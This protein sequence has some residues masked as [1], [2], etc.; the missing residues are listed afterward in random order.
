MSNFGRRDNDG[1][2]NYLI[3]QIALP[4]PF[5]QIDSHQFGTSATYHLPQ[6]PLNPYAAQFGSPYGR[7]AMHQNSQHLAPHYSQGLPE[8]SMSDQTMLKQ[9]HSQYA[10]Q[11]HYIH[12]PKYRLGETDLESQESQNENTMLSEAIVP[13]L[14]GFPDARAFD[15]LIKR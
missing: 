1:N 8:T 2:E 7:Q 9:Q 3:D 5:D 12:S 11:S 6:H 4:L 10:T 15:R 13:A 14:D